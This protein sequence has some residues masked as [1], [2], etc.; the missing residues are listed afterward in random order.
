MSTDRVKYQTFNGDIVPGRLLAVISDEI[1]EREATDGSGR[2]FKNRVREGQIVTLLP[3]GS[4]I[5][6]TKNLAW[7]YPRF[8]S[9]EGLDTMDG[10]PVHPEVL[11]DKAMQQQAERAGA[12]AATELVIEPA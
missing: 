11:T 9:V 4:L 3:N 5:M 12:S 10:Q 6:A 2:V 8:T 7:V 1:Q